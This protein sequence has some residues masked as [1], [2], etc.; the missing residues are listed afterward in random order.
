M[1]QIWVEDSEFFSEAEKILENEETRVSEFWRHKYEEQQGRNWNVFFKD[2]Q[3]RFFDNR[4]YLLSEFEITK[5]DSLLELGCGVGNSLLPILEKIS[6]RAIGIDISK[7]ALEL[8]QKKFEDETRLVLFQKDVSE[9]IEI[10]EITNWE[11][12]KALLIFVLSTIPPKNHFKVI[13]NLDRN[14]KK[15]LVYFRD[16]ARMDL[17][18][19]RF[20]ESKNSKICFFF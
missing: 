2:N 4:N 10:S 1:E 8:F 11:P 5:D 20:A 9:K 12:T 7:R 18:Q 3:D 17:A 15:G 13:E 14:L 19:L 6:C 16:Y